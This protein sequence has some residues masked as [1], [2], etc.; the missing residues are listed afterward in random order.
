MHR[1]GGVGGRP[2]LCAGID[3]EFKYFDDDI[4]RGASELFPEHQNIALSNMFRGRNGAL[5]FACEQ[6]LVSFD[7]RLWSERYKLPKAVEQIYAGLKMRYKNKEEEKLAE[8]IVELDRRL[9][10]VGKTGEQE[11][12]VSALAESLAGLQDRDGVTWIGAQK[13]ILRFEPTKHNWRVFALPEGLLHANRI[14]EDRRGRLWFAD[15]DGHLS[16][17][18]KKSDSWSSHNLA[19]YFPQV[20]PGSIDAIYQD[21]ANRMMF[22]TEAGLIVFVE[23]EKRWSLLTEENSE[24]LG[25]DASSIIDD[26]DGRIWI[27][28][29]GGVLVLEP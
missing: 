14:H 22:A 13:G 3:S 19:K 5:W 8:R 26:K 9:E 18:D 23:S 21:K 20:R 2:P 11:Q 16:V 7:G 28:T 15:D 29:A 27:G 25:D 24:M 17:Y 12:S 1:G 10:R 4:W 6:G